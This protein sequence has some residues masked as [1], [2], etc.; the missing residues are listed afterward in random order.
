M[1][2]NYFIQLFLNKLL[3]NN[4]FISTFEHYQ[5]VFRIVEM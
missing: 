1:T 4:H 5:D 3:F 2:Q